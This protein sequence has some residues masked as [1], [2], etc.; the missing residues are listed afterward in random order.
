MEKN[1][2]LKN[3]YANKLKNWYYELSEKHSFLDGINFKKKKIN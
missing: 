3:D 1:D 2:I